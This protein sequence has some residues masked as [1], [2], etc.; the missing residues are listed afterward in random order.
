VLG[1]PIVTSGPACA[2]IIAIFTGAMETANA[3]RAITRVVWG[4][5]RSSKGR[6]QFGFSG[7]AF[8]MKADHT[9]FRPPHAGYSDRHA[10]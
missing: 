3:T 1:R 10:R 9:G 7:F 5:K 8:G 2:E 4:A 6:S